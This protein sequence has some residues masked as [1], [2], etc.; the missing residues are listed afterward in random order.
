LKKIGFCFLLIVALVFTFSTQPI[1]YGADQDFPQWQV[2]NWWKYNV[3]ILG[4][5]NL[6]GTETYTVV[7]D[8]AEVFQNGQ[9][10]K[11]FEIDGLAGGTIYGNVDSTG[12]SGTWTLTEQQYLA[13]SDLSWVKS[14]STYEETISVNDNSGSIST[15]SAVQDE[16]S[17]KTILDVTYN[18]PFEANKGFPLTVGKSWS[19]ATT[20]IIKTEAKFNG[21]TESTTESEAYTKTFLVLRKE[22]ITISIGE[23]EAYVIKRTDPDGTYAEN[24]YSPEI[25]TD[26][27]IIEYD[28]NG[29]IL[30][31]MELLDYEYKSVGDVLDLL[32]TEI[33]PILVILSIVV[34]IAIVII[35][36]VKKKKPD[37]KS[38]II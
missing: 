2:G 7:S 35:Y 12:T 15:I 13:K 22:S 18:P 31:T 6:V 19:A 20:E 34:I 1:T 25:G 4:E 17:S 9:N 10:F 5:V 32:T 3:E 16:F 38:Q 29:T 24:Y 8:N 26:V 33:F 23:T 27:K 36:L 11:C 14:Y 28:S 21:I 30:M 37:N